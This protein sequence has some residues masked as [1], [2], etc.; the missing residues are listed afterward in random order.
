MP[1]AH[2]LALKKL[3]ENI[4]ERI[5]VDEARLLKA[6]SDDERTKLVEELADLYVRQKELRDVLLGDGD[7]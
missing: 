1:S 5:T 7:S 3:L 4:G 6:T 2:R